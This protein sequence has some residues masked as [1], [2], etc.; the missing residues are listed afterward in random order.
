MK[1]VRESGW[2]YDRWVCSS[3]TCHYEIT[4]SSP[5]RNAKRPFWMDGPEEYE[6][7]I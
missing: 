3:Q 2:H 7:E 6:G 4:I 5:E 1:L